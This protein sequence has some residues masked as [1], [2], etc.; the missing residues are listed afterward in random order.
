MPRCSTLRQV[1]TIS[2]PRSMPIRSRPSSRS[3]VRACCNLRRQIHA[4]EK[5]LTADFVGISFRPE[6]S[7]LVRSGTLE[8]R[9]NKFTT[10]PAL[11][12]DAFLQDLR[13][14]L[15]SFAQIVTAEFQ[16]TSIHAT[17]G[18]ACKL[19]SATTW[20]VPEWT[21]TANNVPVTGTSNGMHRSAGEFRLRSWKAL[22][23]T[24]S[25]SAIPI[26]ADV[27]AAGAR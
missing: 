3:G 25:R 22:D 20:S 11:G 17:P 14:A 19:A 8:V 15:T 26:F 23:E 12:R 21:S 18:P 6:A 16:V 10:Q 9:H 27:T 1:L 2:S 4:I 24:R 5:V 7:R 13:S